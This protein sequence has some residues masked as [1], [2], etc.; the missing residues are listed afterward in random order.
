MSVR[1]IARTNVFDF[2]SWTKHLNRPHCTLTFSS[3]MIVTHFDPTYQTFEHQPGTVSQ[4]PT[5]LTYWMGD[6]G[7]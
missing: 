7:V 6:F 5:Y 1:S 2:F 3:F 4:Y